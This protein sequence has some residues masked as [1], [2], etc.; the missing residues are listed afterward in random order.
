[1]PEP[2]MRRSMALLRIP[3]DQVSATMT[4]HD[5]DPTEV[6]L[7]VPGGVTVAELLTQGDAFLPVIRGRSVCLV[8]RA[9]IA[10]LAVQDVTRL[11]TDGDLPAEKQLVIVH[12][13]GGHTIRGEVQWVAPVGRQRTAD[14]LNDTTTPYI[15]VRADGV[16]H[17]IVKSYISMVEEK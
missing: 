6:L 5:G 7:F 17:F 14:H 10:A 15:E 8:A 11:R 4:L 9:A 13:R 12:L 2:S 3:V 16:V 1:M